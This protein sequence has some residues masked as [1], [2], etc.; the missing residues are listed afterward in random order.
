MSSAILAKN[1]PQFVFYIHLIPKIMAE[2]VPLQNVTTNCDNRLSQ[3]IKA[4]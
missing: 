4:K 2:G 1:K 3:Q